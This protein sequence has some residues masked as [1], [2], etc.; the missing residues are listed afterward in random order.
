MNLQKSFGEKVDWEC[1][2]LGR[3][4]GYNLNYFEFL[5]QEVI[6]VEEGMRLIR[7]FIQHFPKANMGVEPYPLSL[8]SVNWIRFLSSHNIEEVDIDTTLYTQLNLL[9]G[10][11]EYHL[12][13]N[14]LLENGFALLFGAYYFNDSAFYKKAKSILVPELREQ[15]LE[16]GGHF[17][18]SPMYHCIMLYRVL[19][20]YNLV[21]SNTLFRRELEVFLREKAEAMLGW[22][23]EIIYRDGKMPLL[24][25]AAFGIAPLAKDLM[26]YGQRL[27][28]TL[29][30]IHI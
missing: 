1:V 5:N 28:I 27:G 7:D 3:L 12:L 26:E 4:W 6:S 16:D 22:L 24:N 17:E 29:S 21:H 20:C 10:K 25:D 11:L 9:I 8:R 19:D 14:H 15:V 30:L 13:G 23:K 2:E 18:R